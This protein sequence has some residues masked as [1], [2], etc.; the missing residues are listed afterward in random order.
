MD[1]LIVVDVQNDFCEGGALA[2]DGGSQIVPVINA[3]RSK[4]NKV[5]FTQDWHP[6]NHVSF[7]SS[8][9]GEKVLTTITL[10]S[11]KKQELW[12]THCVQNTQGAA[13]REDLIVEPTDRIVKKGLNQDHDSY[14]AFGCEEDRTN[15]EKK[16]KKIEI[17]RVFVCGLAFDFCAGKTALDARSFGLETFFIT[18]ASR[19][20]SQATH[21]AME[22]KLLENGVKLITSNEI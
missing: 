19:S 12:P 14:S 6:P 20:I 7:A 22:E 21:Q 13:L 18:D 3:I 1:V 5:I 16:L 15:L 4:F 17:R 10:N 11:G 2:V 9:P 8:H